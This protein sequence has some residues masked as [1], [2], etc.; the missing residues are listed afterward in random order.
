M[1]VKKVVQEEQEEL[2]DFLKI[3]NLGVKQVVQKSL[4][5]GFRIPRKLWFT[6]ELTVS[7]MFLD[8]ILMYPDVFYLV[9]QDMRS[10]S[11]ADFLSIIKFSDDNT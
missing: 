6:C 2:E 5:E 7:Q 1:V 10:L 11:K 8:D 3:Q 4:N 9:L